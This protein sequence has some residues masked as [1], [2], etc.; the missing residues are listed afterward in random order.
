MKTIRAKSRPMS[1]G[2]VA[3]LGGVAV[4]AL[5]AAGSIASRRWRFRYPLLTPISLLLYALTGFVA[6]REGDHFLVGAAAGAAVAAVEATAGWRVS[7][8][9]GADD[10]SR[11]SERMEAGVAGALTVTGAVLGGLAGIA[12]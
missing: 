10:E 6:A 7:R 12:A 4:L 9:L 1:P 8:A 3:L 5:D 11:V 2:L